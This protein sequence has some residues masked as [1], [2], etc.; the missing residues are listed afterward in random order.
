MSPDIGSM[1][2]L[3]LITLYG[4]LTEQRV[5]SPNCGLVTSRKVFALKPVVSLAKKIE[6]A[7]KTTSSTK[8]PVRSCISVKCYHSFDYCKR[9]IS[10]YNSAVTLDVFE[11]VAC[12]M[13]RVERY[14]LNVT[15]TMQQPF[16]EHSRAHVRLRRCKNAPVASVA[17]T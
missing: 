14:A 6:F 17:A 3:T 15:R 1:M 5:T 8:N 9:S 10:F 4:W 16:Q 11:A 7:I 2:S 12:Y 13:Q